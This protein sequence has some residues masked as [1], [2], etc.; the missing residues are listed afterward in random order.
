MSRNR[1]TSG[2]SAAL[3]FTLLGACTTSEQHVPPAPP[4]PDQ[5]ALVEP[6]KAPS[7]Y[8]IAAGDTAI[9]GMASYVVRD[10]DTLLDIARDYDLGYTQQIG[11]ASCRERVFRRV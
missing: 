5:G 2:L 3:I 6:E 10:E 4:G 7:S 8:K 9:G 11:R 1:T